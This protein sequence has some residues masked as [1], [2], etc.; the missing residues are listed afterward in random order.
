[1]ASMLTMAKAS[2]TSNK[3]T[4]STDQPTRASNLSMAPTGALVNSAGRAA[5]LWYPTTLASTGKPS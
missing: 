1:M 2:F 4:S 3:S 5:W